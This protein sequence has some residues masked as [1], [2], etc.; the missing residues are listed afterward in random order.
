[1]DG[2]FLFKII[3]PNMKIK[4]VII[5][6]IAV[7]LP[8]VGMPEDAE[9][10]IPT[11]HWSS[12]NVDYI[13][14]GNETEN[15]KW[16]RLTELVKLPISRYSGLG[17]VSYLKRAVWQFT[18]Q[19]LIAEIAENKEVDHE[20][21]IAAMEKLEYMASLAE[22]VKNGDNPGSNADTMDYQKNA[23]FEPT[24]M[25]SA[26]QDET[27]KPVTANEKKQPTW[28]W[29]LAVPAFAFLWLVVR[30]SRRCK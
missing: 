28:L 19:E 1:M 15:E 29:W 4:R 2:I 3:K 18:D 12:S 5:I 22:A 20:V 13:L 26:A 6:I 23:A 10:T 11:R 16:I 27:T 21:R 30:L 9:K 24:A 17:P 25:E 8:Q 14:N 7:I